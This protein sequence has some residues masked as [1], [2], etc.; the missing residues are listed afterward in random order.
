MP[1]MPGSAVSPRTVDDVDSPR[2]R[3]VRAGWIAADL[4]A[5]DQQGRILD[6][7]GAGAV[8]DAQMRDRDLPRRYVDERLHVGAELRR[9][10]ED[11]GRDSRRAEHQGADRE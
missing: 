3:R 7:R 8:D 10:R 1:T 11:G 9:R 6:R 4:R 5:V 2:E